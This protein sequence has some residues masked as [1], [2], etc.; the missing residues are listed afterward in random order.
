[1][2]LS[3]LTLVAACSATRP[4]NRFGGDSVTLRIGTTDGLLR[5]TSRSFAQQTFVS[6]LERLSGGR[7][8]VEVVTDVGGGQPD[9]ESQL[10]AQVANGD[11]DAGYPATRAFASSGIEGLEAIEAPFVLTNPEAVQDVLTGEGAQLMRDSVQGN[12]LVALDFAFDGLRIPFAATEPLRSTQAWAGTRFR[13]YG[14]PVQAEAVRALGG[15]PVAVTHHW[16]GMVQAGKLDGVE[17]TLDGYHETSPPD[18]TPQVAPNVVLWP[19]VFVFTVNETFFDGLS[20]QHQQWLVEA[21]RLARDAGFAEPRDDDEVARRLCDDGVRFREASDRQLAGLRR[22]VAPVNEA[23]AADHESG[24]LME[25]VQAAAMRLPQVSSPVVPAGCD[26]DKDAPDE[27]GPPSRLPDGVYRVQISVADVEA[28]GL[29]NGDGWSGIWTLDVNDATYALTCRPL[30]L[31]GRDCGQEDSD[32]VFEAGHLVGT[33]DRVAFVSD[34]DV[35]PPDAEIGCTPPESSGLTGC[36]PAPTY[37][38]TWALED[39][40]LLF[41]EGDGHGASTLL[42]NP[43]VRIS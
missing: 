36:G 3:L 33:G 21:A 29:S 6:E 16:A 27:V 43:W 12:N 11:L 40:T 37:T 42:I 17:L 19:K 41:T 1:M 15:Q 26:G 2:A 34:F 4:V 22:A 14:S 38:A 39:H 28:A 35:L 20:P 23:L 5:V 10:V 24:P 25:Q 31:P 30:T 18:V 13:V 7:I 9:A 8:R 32:G